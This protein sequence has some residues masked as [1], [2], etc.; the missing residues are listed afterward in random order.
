MTKSWTTNS[1]EETVQ[2]GRE[3][4]ALLR[5]PLLLI[6]RGDLGAGVWDFGI[7]NKGARA[8]FTTLTRSS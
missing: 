4:A 7:C 6:L 3:L 1:A 8:S 2:V 5:P